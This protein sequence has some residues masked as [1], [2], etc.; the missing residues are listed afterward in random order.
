MAEPWIKMRTDLAT[1]PK[2]VAIAELLNLDEDTVVG[3][4]HRL[5]SWADKHAKDGRAMGSPAWLDR[6]MKCKGLANALMRDEIDWLQAEDG[7]LVFPRW[8]EHNSQSAKSRAEAARRQ[9]TSRENRT[10][11]TD[12]CDRTVTPVT[13]SANKSATRGKERRGE[14]KR[15]PA[16]PAGKIPAR[17]GD[18]HLPPP[19]GGT[20]AEQQEQQPISVIGSSAMI[21]PSGLRLTCEAIIDGSDAPS[22]RPEVATGAGAPDGATKPVGDSPARQALLAAIT[23]TGATGSKPRA[24]VMAAQDA[25]VPLLGALVREFREQVKREKDAGRPVSG[26][27]LL[28]KRLDEFLAVT[29]AHDP[30]IGHATELAMRYEADDRAKA[31]RTA[32]RAAEVSRCQGSKV[33]GDPPSTPRHL[34]TSTPAAAVVPGITDHPAFRNL[35]TE[36]AEARGGIHA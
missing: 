12:S 25:D 13:D 5:W 29:D 20:P 30:M 19:S 14:K 1:N 27:G 6:M 33:P 4:M 21:P 28:L 10:P 2:V 32:Q 15:T 7:W 8:E 16:A 17:D 22:G 9:R 31:A 23:A 24:I 18:P 35:T 11:V 26:P 3:K 36:S 34:T